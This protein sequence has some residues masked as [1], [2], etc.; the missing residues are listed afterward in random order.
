M[1]A[2]AFAP[3]SKLLQQQ[4]L[5]HD[6]EKATIRVQFQAGAELCNPAGVVQGGILASMLDDALGSLT[7][8]TAKEN[9]FTPTL[10][11]KVSFLRAASPGQFIVEGQ[12]IKK[13]KNVFF[14][15][16]QLYDSNNSKIATMSATAMLIN[17]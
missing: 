11:F 2:K 1:T 13:G 10:E 9:E 8:L 5:H 16:G 7:F 12:I 17:S 4:I 3:I 14:V 15:E 6:A